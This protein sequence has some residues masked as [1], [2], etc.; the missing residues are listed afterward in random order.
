MR[1][2]VVETVRDVC[3]DLS[4]EPHTNTRPYVRSHICSLFLLVFRP[5]YTYSLM[6]ASLLIYS[7]EFACIYYFQQ[8]DFI[9]NSFT[10]G[11]QNLAAT[12]RLWN[13]TGDYTHV[14]FDTCE[15]GAKGEKINKTRK[16]TKQKK[17]KETRNTLKKN[18]YAKPKRFI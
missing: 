18:H 5:T 13:K 3:M 14:S 7:H 6:R 2:N 15:H 4:D 17:K 9:P 8:F 1:D 12:L 10:Y 11:E 16:R